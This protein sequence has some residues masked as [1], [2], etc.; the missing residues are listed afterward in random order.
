MLGCVEGPMMCKLQRNTLRTIAV[1]VCLDGAGEG[2]E[3]YSLHFL[4][5]G[6]VNKM[7]MTLS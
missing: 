6:A 4:S 5:L 1:V 2:L 3:C 7:W